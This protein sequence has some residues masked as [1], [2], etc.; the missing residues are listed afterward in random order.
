M[1][2]QIV[3]LDDDL[4]SLEVRRKALA[5]PRGP[6]GV[7]CRTAGLVQTGLDVA[8]PNLDFI[9]DEGLLFGVERLDPELFRALAILARWNISRI[10]VSRAIRSSAVTLAAFN[11]SISAWFDA[12]SEAM[13]STIALSASRSSG[14]CR[15]A[16]VM[17]GSEHKTTWISSTFQRTKSVCRRLLPSR[18]RSAHGDGTHLLPVHPI[19]Q[20]QELSLAQL[21]A[22]MANARPAE[23]GL[24]Q[25]LGIK[26][27]PVP[28]HQTILIRSARL[29]R[30]T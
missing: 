22:V 23:R 10:E 15:S 3:G 20:R 12:R 26:A 11:R 16:G 29:A 27:K 19:D 2:G 4:D 9:E 5:R 7:G 14:I 25:P 13:A 1:T 17:A 30:N 24:L 21:H 18:L 8:E 6:L 28:S